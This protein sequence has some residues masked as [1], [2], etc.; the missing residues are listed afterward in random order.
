MRQVHVNWWVSSWDRRM[1]NCKGKVDSRK[2]GKS[3]RN[4]MLHGT[5][6]RS[7]KTA[8]LLKRGHRP[9]ELGIHQ[10]LA[11]SCVRERGWEKRRRVEI[12]E[13][14]RRGESYC[15]SSLDK[16][17]ESRGQE[18]SSKSTGTFS[19]K[20]QGPISP[21][22]DWQGWGSKGLALRNRALCAF[23]YGFTH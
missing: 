13:A 18:S 11:R 7:P 19:L 6:W 3:Y 15:K 1:R 22:A 21:G 5:K 23:L 8:T 9:A 2:S 10:R 12:E 14:G 16:S 20:W 17:E 4:R